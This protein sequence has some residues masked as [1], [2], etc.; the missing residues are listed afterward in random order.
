MRVVPTVSRVDGPSTVSDFT[1]AVYV[2]ISD[3]GENIFGSSNYRTLK[4]N[5]LFVYLIPSNP[6]SCGVSELEYVGESSVTEVL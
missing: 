5:P 4:A 1:V 3:V 6:L 2:S